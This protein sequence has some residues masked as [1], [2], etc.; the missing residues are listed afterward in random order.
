MID[1]F[2][3]IFDIYEISAL[4]FDLLRASYSL[5]FLS[6][7]LHRVYGVKPIILLDEYDTPMQEA[8][9]NGYWDELAQFV[10]AFMNLS[11]KD[12][13]SLER[14]LLTGITRVSKESI[15]SDLNN[16]DVITVLH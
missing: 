1:I 10:R 7:A 15:F 16:P 11:F 2:Y 4:S 8:W 14:A 9:L 5:R 3:H 13:P 12:N 6:T